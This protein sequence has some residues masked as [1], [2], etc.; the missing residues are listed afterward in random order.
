MKKTFMFGLVFSLLAAVSVQTIAQDKKAGKDVKTEETK[1]SAVTQAA[2]G[3]K[4]FNTICPVT[5][6]D[7]EKDATV[8][9][10]QGKNYGLCCKRCVKKFE[11]EPEKYSKMVSEDGKK[12]IK[13]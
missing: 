2:K 5:G 4:A 3:V 13:K 9:T 12:F 6:E 11:K 8:L 10:Y 1:S 7:L